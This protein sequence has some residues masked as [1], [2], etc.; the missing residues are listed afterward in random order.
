MSELVVAKYLD[1]IYKDGARGERSPC[2]RL[3]L[4]C[5]GLA[6]LARVELYGRQLLASRG[7]EYQHDPEGFTARYREQ[8]AE[9]VEIQ[10]PVPGCVVAVIR[11]RTGYCCHV[12][13]VVHDMNR[14]GL[15][16]HV[17]EINPGQNARMIP[18]YRFRE[19]NSLR[20]LKYYDDPG[21]PQQ[22]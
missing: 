14:T 12:G 21:L 18:L 7:G 11:R 20:V 13:L 3:L 15:G 4:D 19:A 16:L 8:I 10:E 22:A 9:M 2:G 6:R 17:L 5:W 1:A